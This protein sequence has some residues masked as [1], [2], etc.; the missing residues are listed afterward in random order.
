MVSKTLTNLSPSAPKVMI[1]P[2]K[3]MLYPTAILLILALSASLAAADPRPGQLGGLA[4]DFTLNAYGGG[5]YTLS[6]YRGK[7]VMMFV[8]GYG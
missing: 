2:R 8:V 6:D 7:V 1:M 3:F 4:P 5:S